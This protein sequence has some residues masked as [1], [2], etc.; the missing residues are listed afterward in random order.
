LSVPVLSEYIAIKDAEPRRVEDIS[1]SE[2]LTVAGPVAVLIGLLVLAS[3]IR[4]KP[5]AAASADNV[6]PPL[7]GA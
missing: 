7:P 6:T 3:S 4:G 1:V 2:W 5:L